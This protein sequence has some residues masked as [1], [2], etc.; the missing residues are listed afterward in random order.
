MTTGST[1]AGDRGKDP[2]LAVAH[3][4]A[5]CPP[6]QNIRAADPRGWVDSVGEVVPLSHQHASVVLTVD[7][8]AES[9]ELTRE[10]P[11]VAMST[12]R[13]SHS[14]FSVSKAEKSNFFSFVSYPTT[15]K[16]FPV[17]EFLS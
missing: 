3:W 13:T 16:R 4:A 7:L 11:P 2:T 1:C 17:F 14:F 8:S 5:L 9:T 6:P 12:T 15:K 10:P